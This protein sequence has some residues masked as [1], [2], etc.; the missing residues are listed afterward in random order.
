MT[1]LP[2]GD[3]IT[4][5]NDRTLTSAIA[6]YLEFFIFFYLEFFSEAL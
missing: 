4:I 5:K 2:V 3:V 6:F 1:L